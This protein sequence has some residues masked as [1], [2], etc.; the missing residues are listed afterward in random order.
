MKSDDD[1]VFY[2]W[3]DVTD[4]LQ[5]IVFYAD[6]FARGHHHH[7]IHRMLGGYFP[8]IS[9]EKMSLIRIK[10]IEW[11]RDMATNLD[12]KIYLAKSI[13]R[14]ERVFANPNEKTRNVLTA[15]NQLTHLLG[16]ADAQDEAGPEEMAVWIR[17]FNKAAKAASDGS[18][19]E[20]AKN[21]EKYFWGNLKND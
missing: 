14:L 1:R 19:Y 9:A 5:A 7:E 17:N 3:D 15:D 10:A 12:R 21:P 20:A 2:G 13:L 18:A 6:M 11:M 16:L 8:N 4:F